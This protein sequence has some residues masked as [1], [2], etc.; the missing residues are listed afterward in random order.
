MSNSNKIIFHC[1][2]KRNLLQ[3]IFSKSNDDT[4]N[5]NYI[6][7]KGHKFFSNNGDVNTKENN[8]LLKICILYFL[9]NNSCSKIKSEWSRQV[10]IDKSGIGTITFKKGKSKCNMNI[11]FLLQFIQIFPF[12][13]FEQLN[14]LSVYYKQ[15]E[16][17]RNENKNFHDLIYLKQNEKHITK[18]SL[19]MK[20]N[21]L[22]RELISGTEAFKEE[23]IKILRYIYN[24]IIQQ[25]SFQNNRSN[26]RQ[27]NNE[28]YQN[29]QNKLYRKAFIIALLYSYPRLDMKIPSIYISFLP[30]KYI[31]VHKIPFS[32]SPHFPM[33]NDFYGSNYGRFALIKPKKGLLHFIHNENDLDQILK[34]MA[35]RSPALY[36]DEMLNTIYQKYNIQELTTNVFINITKNQNNGLYNHI[37]KLNQKRKGNIRNQIKDSFIDETMIELFVFYLNHVDITSQSIKNSMKSSYDSVLSSMK[38]KFGYTSTNQDLSTRHILLKYKKIQ[39]KLNIYRI[40]FKKDVKSVSLPYFT[41]C[42]IAKYTSYISF[43][44]LKIFYRVLNRFDKVIREKLL[45][46]PIFIQMALIYILLFVPNSFFDTH[47]KKIFENPTKGISKTYYDIA[48]TIFRGIG[49]SFGIPDLGV[50]QKIQPSTLEENIHQHI[51]FLLKYNSE[52][53]A[54]CKYIHAKCILKNYQK[55]CISVDPNLTETKTKNQNAFEKIK[56]NAIYLSK[57]IQSF[58]KSLQPKNRVVCINS[59]SSNQI[60]HP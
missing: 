1:G 2:Q 52:I 18:S 29:Y 6:K 45:Y 28:K 11:P 49:I 9:D 31:K 12:Y 48:F 26:H 23:N 27:I 33:I 55:F 16:N 21:I 10:H 35:Q 13:T 40:E 24:R 8:I 37:N 5:K 4:F 19:N 53:S 36:N 30:G 59:S 34:S 42:E 3:S 25:I 41:V 60:N 44:Q 58:T 32:V 46:D 47:F 17:E 43:R 14:I 54:S 57:I 38:S 15:Y 56:N 22:L 7:L 51:L 50:I 20:P 39:G